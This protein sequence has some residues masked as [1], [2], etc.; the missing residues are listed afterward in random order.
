MIALRE[1]NFRLYWFGQAVSNI[2]NWMQIVALRWF[3]L[4]ISGSALALGLIGLAQALPLF[5]FSLTGG[6]LAD[7]FPRLFVLL[8]TQSCAMV[9]AVVLAL[10][11]SMGKP[12]L[13]S[14]LLVA[15][16]A[17]AITAIDNPARQAFLSDLVPKKALLN[18]VALNASV[19]NGAA[20]IG[21]TLSGL[22][23]LK[24]GA[25][26]CF[27]L[28]A[29]SFL[30]VLAALLMI[31]R[32]Q[33]LSLWNGKEP[34]TAEVGQFNTPPP[35]MATIRV[36]ARLRHER[37][38]LA[39]LAVAAAA[40]LLGRPYL[41]LMPAFAKSVQHVGP[42]GLGLMVA[43]SGFGSLVGS[44]VLA[45]LT[46]SRRLQLWL[47]ICGVGFGVGLMLFALMQALSGA[48]FL[49]VVCG[50]GATMTMTVANTLLQMHAPVGMRG[51]VMSLYTLIA[52]GLTPLGAFVVS[53]V[54]TVFGLGSATIAAGIG[55]TIVALVG[56]LMVVPSASPPQDTREGYPYHGRTDLP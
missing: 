8:V 47:A 24:V 1:R 38:I 55:V 12:P 45:A 23:L 21:P 26:G 44:I 18:A 15:T 29:G 7:R 9:L 10:L 32:S 33:R 49:L 50:A 48:L 14:L 31:A 35:R 22:L 46:S 16:V 40:S 3:V 43:C 30:A 51:R 2:G 37:V 4:Q 6:M 25:F 34:Q 27:L 17:A 5:A 28:N 39:V 41:L 11:A 53:A 13:W 54:A 42:T 56:Y 20:V 52:A 19:Y 36:L